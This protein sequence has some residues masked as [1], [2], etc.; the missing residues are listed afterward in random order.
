MHKINVSKYDSKLAG[1]LTYS[2][3]EL[4]KSDTRLYRA[5]SYTFIFGR[6]R[7]KLLIDLNRRIMLPGLKIKI[8][9]DC[10]L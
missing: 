6:L 7:N 9:T 5:G 2:E 8:L 1:M 10:D 4:V 3:R